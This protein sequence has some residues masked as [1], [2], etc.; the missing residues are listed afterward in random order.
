MAEALRRITQ[1]ILDMSWESLRYALLFFVVL[2]TANF[3]CTVFFKTIAFRLTREITILC[4]DKVYEKY[5]DFKIR[6]Y[7]YAQ[8]NKYIKSLE[9]IVVEQ[10]GAKLIARYKK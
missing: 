3:L 5:K 7:G 1:A 2:I 9:H 10:N 6:D 8:F 4:E